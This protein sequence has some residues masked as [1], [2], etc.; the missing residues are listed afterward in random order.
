M[1]HGNSLP[2]SQAEQAMATHSSVLAWRVLWTEEPGGLLSMGSHRV[3]H[4]WSNLACMHAYI[5]EGNGDPLQYSCL[6]NPRDGGA[7][8]AAAY[9]VTQSQTQLKRLS[10]SS[11]SSKSEDL[12][13]INNDYKSN[14]PSYGKSKKVAWL[15]LAPW[16]TSFFFFYGIKP[17]LAVELVDTLTLEKKMVKNVS[18]TWVYILKSL[19]IKA[20]TSLN[21]SYKP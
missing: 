19:A 20:P 7:W 11:S 21:K 5:G 2:I 16:Q 13:W 6:E 14:S 9:G 8:W 1:K 4:N 10:S 18:S 12:K 17:F 3:G 15:F